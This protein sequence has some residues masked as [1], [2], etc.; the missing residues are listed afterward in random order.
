MYSSP[1]T[2][3]WQTDKYEEEMWIP[4]EFEEYS[5]PHGVGIVKAWPNGATVKGWGEDDFMKN[6]RRNLFRYQNAKL[7]YEE[8]N[9]PT[10]F[11]MRS[12]QIVCIDIDGKNGG[13]EHAQE[14]LGNAPPTL[15]ERSKSGN[16]YHLFYLAPDT[17]DQSLGFAMFSDSIG[18]VTGVDIRATGCVYHWE[19]QRWN[20]RSIV[21]LPQW[22]HDKLS[23]RE[24]IRRE[25]QQ[26]IIEI[27]TIGETEKL[28]LHDSLLED[29]KRDIPEGKRN[30]TLFALGSQMLEAKVPEWDLLIEQRAAQLGLGIVETDKLIQNI[31]R[32]A[33]KS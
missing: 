23:R 12:M 33:A 17:W 2:W 20:N 22:I 6:Y 16:G 21:E 4:P 28:M 24:R 18:I 9:L 27:D 13:F 31:S 30:T 26:L 11:L 25:R 15:A 7:H 29:L 19:H 8:Q 14:L 32:Y 10:A 5:G 3:W 1:P